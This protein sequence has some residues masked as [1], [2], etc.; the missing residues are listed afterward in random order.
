VTQS[1]T[2]GR[3]RV[4]AFFVIDRRSPAWN[5]CSGERSGGGIGVA[6]DVLHRWLVASGDGAAEG[7]PYEGVRF[8]ALFVALS[9]GL[10]VGLAL[11]FN[12][13]ADGVGFEDEGFWTAPHVLVYGGGLGL[14]AVLGST[15]LGNRRHVD[16]WRAAIPVGYGLGLVGLVLFGVAGGADFVW[17]TVISHEDTALEGM[18]SPPHL[19]LAVGGGLFL[20][21]PLRAAWRREQAR[22]WALLPA[23]CALSFALSIAVIFTA[24]LN[25]LAATQVLWSPDVGRNMGLAGMV[26]FPAVLLAV[27]LAL[28]RRFELP[29]GALTLVFLGPGVVSVGTNGN[30][31]LLLPVVAAGLVADCVVAV[32]RPVPANPRALRLFGAAVP[33]TF[34]ASFFATV[35]LWHGLLPVWTTHLWT[36]AVAVA[37][38]AGVLLTYAVYPD[39]R[40]EKRGE[41]S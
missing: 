8:D 33:V 37:G 39:C 41:R 38:I 2:L 4:T 9:V 1:V 15:V 32:R 26:A 40:R 5:A 18:T 14:A 3:K 12:V 23:L 10:M 7:R 31:E 24:Y 19:G 36:G 21:S 34:A 30:V 28:V 35:A 13:H 6:L 25:P 29:A 22:G 16:G 20:T 27:S 11:D 17:H